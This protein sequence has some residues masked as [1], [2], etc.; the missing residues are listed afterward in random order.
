MYCEGVS[1]VLLLILSLWFLQSRRAGK[2][3]A[4]FNIDAA[5]PAAMDAGSWENPKS[6]IPPLS[7]VTILEFMRA[8][9]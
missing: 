4:L 8:K 7:R 9:V 5:R 3:A 1:F 2:P 6:E